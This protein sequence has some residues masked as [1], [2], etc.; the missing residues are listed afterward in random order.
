MINNLKKFISCNLLIFIPWI[1]LGLASWIYLIHKHEQS[2]HATGTVLG[3]IIAASI[4]V[5]I[6]LFCLCFIIWVI[7]YT[8]AFRLKTKFI[9][10]NKFYNL[11]FTISLFLSVIVLIGFLA[12][13]LYAF[14]PSF[15]H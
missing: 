14:L 6:G 13:V 4:F 5:V 11:F 15:I 3:F 7:E 10:E 12:L 2:I 8:T 9:L 1:A